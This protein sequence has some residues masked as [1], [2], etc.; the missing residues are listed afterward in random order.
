[1]GSLEEMVIDESDLEEDPNNEE[2]VSVKNRT[3][4]SEH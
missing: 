1:M 2:V 4:R 3:P